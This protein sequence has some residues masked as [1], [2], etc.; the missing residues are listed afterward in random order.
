MGRTGNKGEWSETYVLL[1]ILSTGKLYAS[2]N[3][4]HKNDKL[5]YCVN[6]VIRQDNEYI[7][8][9]DDIWYGSPEKHIPKSRFKENAELVRSKMLT[10]KSSFSIEPVDDFLTSIGC[11]QFKSG[12]RN[13]SDIVLEIHDPR[14][15]TDHVLGFSI[16]SA[17][18]SKPTLLNASRS[19]NFTFRLE[20]DMSDDLASLANEIE[21]K[22]ERYKSLRDA[23]VEF[24]FDKVDEPIFQ[25][26][27][28]LIDSRLPEIVAQMLLLYYVDGIHDISEQA[29]MME[30]TNPL[31][32]DGTHVPYYHYKIKKLLSAS[33]L[34][35]VPKTVW[36]GLEDATGGIIIA[37]EEPVCFHIYNRNEFEEYLLEMTKLDSPSSSRHKYS[38]VEKDEEG[39]YVKLNLQIRFK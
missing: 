27:L 24:K 39:Y 31:G 1:H 9:D 13:K 17:F 5:Y 25:E 36:S 21:S 12:A 2:D 7:I 30:R 4:G 6:K 29:G 18:G 20:G 23:G 37:A 28:E 11:T 26:N 38:F 33:A 3:K 34:G 32:F 19:T 15:S 22:N 14:T 16:K 8:G 35:M 10:E